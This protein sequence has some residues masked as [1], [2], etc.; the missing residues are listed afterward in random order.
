[1]LI[2]TKDFLK[3]YTEAEEKSRVP[4][5]TGF[6]A[7]DREKTKAI[8]LEFER[9]ITF[10]EVLVK[11]KFCSMY[12]LRKGESLYE[13]GVIKYNNTP[14]AAWDVAE[15]FA[16]RDKIQDWFVSAKIAYLKNRM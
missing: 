1:M 4:Y 2:T 13:Y 5:Y 10:I 16:V 8:G 9:L 14:Q 11:L 7:V 3:N 12:T 6:L 15:E